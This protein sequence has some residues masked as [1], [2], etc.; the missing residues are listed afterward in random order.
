MLELI[1]MTFLSFRNGVRAKT[2][3]Q[4]PFMWGFITFFAYIAAM[5]IGTLFVIQ[6]FCHGAIDL[7]HFSSLD[8]KARNAAAQQLAQVLSANPLNIV[9]IDLFGIGGYLLIRYILEKKPNKKEP[10][11][12][13]MDKL[14][15]QQDS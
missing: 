7:D 3:D 8:L 14:G 6:L 9:T 4:N 10:E 13:W 12:H 2:K 15:E 5:V 11:V 1:M